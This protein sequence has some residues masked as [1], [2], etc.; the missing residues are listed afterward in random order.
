MKLSV[1]NRMTESRMN[2]N[3]KPALQLIETFFDELEAERFYT[4]VSYQEGVTHVRLLQPSRSKPGFRV[5]ALMVDQD[6]PAGSEPDGVRR[7]VVTDSILA[8]FDKV[9]HSLNDRSEDRSER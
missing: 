7:I 3:P 9:S 1:P 4:N 2:R 5:Q 6:I 8:L